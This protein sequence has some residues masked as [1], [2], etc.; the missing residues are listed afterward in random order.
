[1]ER[2]L[3]WLK[4]MIYEEKK[5]EKISVEFSMA[6]LEYQN[7]AHC[8]LHENYSGATPP[9]NNCNICWGIYSQKCKH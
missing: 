3:R 2:V 9:I 8:K 1:M 7:Q 6:P 5:P 4:S